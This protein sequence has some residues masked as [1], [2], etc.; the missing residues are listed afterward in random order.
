MIVIGCHKCALDLDI[1][2]VTKGRGKSPKFFDV[3]I[4]GH[5]S[6]TRGEVP[7]CGS[8]VAFYPHEYSL[9]TSS[10]LTHSQHGAHWSVTGCGVSDWRVM[11][12]FRSALRSNS[13]PSWLEDGPNFLCIT[14]GALPLRMRRCLSS[15]YIRTFFT[16][17]TIVSFAWKLFFFFVAQIRNE[18]VEH[19]R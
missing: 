2:N 11:V 1:V 13:D 17:N 5:M 14:S 3:T 12:V 9:I 8:L 10:D 7:G 6:F 16:R 18:Q 15:A 4:Y 19:L